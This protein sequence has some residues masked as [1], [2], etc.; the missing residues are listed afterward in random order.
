MKT[1]NLLLALLLAVCVVGCENSE[2]ID[3]QQDRESLEGQLDEA[4]AAV[5]EKET[6][7]EKLKADNLEAQSKAMEGISAIITKEQAQKE[8]LNEQ[9]GEKNQE[10]QTLKEKVVALQAQIDTHVCPAPETII[11]EEVEVEAEE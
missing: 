5:A 6:K 4:N 9:L 1:L 10:I 2:L 11:I 3:C 8:K 7:I